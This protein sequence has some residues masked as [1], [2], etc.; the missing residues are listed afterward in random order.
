MR[1]LYICHGDFRFLSRAKKQ[2]DGLIENGYEV[3]V[4][5]YLFEADIDYNFLNYDIR[6]VII[7]Q[8]KCSLTN[9]YNL[10]LFNLKVNKFYSD[11]CGIIICRELS[12]LLSGVLV[13]RKTHAKLIYDSNELS[14]ETFFGIRKV[15][16]RIIESILIRKVD[17]IIH[18]NKYRLEY[19]VKKYK[20]SKENNFVVENFASYYPLPLR[21]NTLNEKLKVIYFGAIGDRRNIEDLVLAAGSIEGI[22]LDLIGFGS[23]E[24]LNKI[25]EIIELN[26]IVNVNI[27]DA[28]DES[29]LP[30]ILKDYHIGIAFYPNVELNNWY[31]ASNKVWQYLQG[32]LSIIATNNPPI[33]DLV[34]KYNVGVCLKTI[35]IINLK[36]ALNLSIKNKYWEK[37]TEEF[38]LNYSWESNKSDFLEVLK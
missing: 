27:K 33:T 32:G 10:F 23:N 11:D 17:K 31:C 8:N 16:W 20:L 30:S 37:I 5:N 6:K 29:L 38:R 22:D 24:F 13:K 2:V 19:F 28:I 7:P 26:R 35:D 3:E 21:K 12:V 15:F 9:I 14:V 34:N 36:L 18:A 4:L 25:K 1:V